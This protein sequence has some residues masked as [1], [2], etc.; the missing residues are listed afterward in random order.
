MKNS[1]FQQ[2]NE[3]TQPNTMQLFNMVRS[4]SNPQQMLNDLAANNKQLNA[5]LQEVQQNG[6]DAKSLFFKKV[7]QMGIDPKQVLNMLK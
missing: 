4:S 2:L 7:Q 5:V 1:L 6:G 3:Q